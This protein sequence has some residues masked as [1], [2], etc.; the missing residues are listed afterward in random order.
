MLEQQKQT[1]V[2]HWTAAH[3][4]LDNTNQFRYPQHSNIVILKI[5]MKQIKAF[6]RFGLMFNRTE[7]SKQMTTV[8]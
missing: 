4:A 8:V 3:N 6:L 2:T 7:K 1:H 5:T